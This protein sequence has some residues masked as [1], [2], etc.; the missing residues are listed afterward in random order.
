[1]TCDKPLHE[2]LKKYDMYDTAFNKHS[3]TLI[4]GKP[5]QGKSSLLYSFFKSKD[6]LRKCF[7][8]IYYICPSNSMDSMADN[9]FS[10]LPDDQIYNELDGEILDE[11]IERTHDR[12]E[13]DDKTCIIIDDM[14]SQLK[15]GDVQ[16]RLKQIA[17]NKRHMNIYQT[18]I[19]TQTWKSVPPE[20][21]RLLDNIFLFKVN[22]NDM[23]T[24]MTEM[25][26]QYKDKAYAIQKIVYDKPHQYL[27]INL[28]EGR[29]FKKFDELIIKDE[30]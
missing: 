30:D 8:K 10:K 21:R 2:K 13:K 28:K 29:L 16:K 7:D 17:M 12:E 22:P 9:I 4:A 19:L 23:E 14:G 25:L 24:I 6:C 1:M 27:L 11:I 5:G 3:T 26:P 20:V 15:N 18:F